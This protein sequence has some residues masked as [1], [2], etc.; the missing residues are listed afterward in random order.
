MINKEKEQELILAQEEQIIAAILSRKKIYISED[1]YLSFDDVMLAIYDNESMSRLFNTYLELMHKEN[2]QARIVSLQEDSAI[3]IAEK[4]G[5]IRL[6]WLKN[7]EN[8]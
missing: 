7:K 6:N 1:L 5:E 8:L 4:Y 2:V 3:K